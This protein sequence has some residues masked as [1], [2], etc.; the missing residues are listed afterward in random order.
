MD[1]L[2]IQL[3]N[4]SCVNVDGTISTDTTAASGCTKVAPGTILAI[5]PPNTYTIPVSNTTPSS[6]I[7]YGLVSE[8]NFNER[9]DY[10]HILDSLSKVCPYGAF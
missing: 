7:D 2:L 6:Y 10:G 3:Q 4:L 5:A 9:E 1:L 8:P